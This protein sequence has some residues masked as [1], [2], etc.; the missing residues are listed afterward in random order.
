MAPLGAQQIKGLGENQQEA[1]DANLATPK[2]KGPIAWPV[3]GITSWLG[4]PL[5]FNLFQA[6][7]TTLFVG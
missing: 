4:I 6:V 3:R 2:K 5:F 1:G 7:E